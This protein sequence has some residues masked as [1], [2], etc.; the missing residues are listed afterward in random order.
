MLRPLVL[1]ALLGSVFPGA[2]TAN[3]N[4]PPQGQA[5]AGAP[6][7]PAEYTL[8]E[9][10]SIDVQRGAVTVKHGPIVH[11]GMPDMTMRY[12]LDDPGSMMSL[13]PGD[14][15]FFRAENRDGILVITHVAPS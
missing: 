15:I 1:G 14:K 2:A 4:R 5:G 9:I 8:G 12:R 11:L 6:V 13:H 3:A 10:K 7:V